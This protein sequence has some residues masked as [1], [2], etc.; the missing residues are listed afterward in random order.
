[1][2]YIWEDSLKPSGLS[3]LLQ[4]GDCGAAGARTCPRSESKA[5]AGLGDHPGLLLLAQ[6]SVLCSN[7][8]SPGPC[9]KLAGAFCGTLHT[10]SRLCL[11]RAALVP[12][13]SFGENELFDQVENSPGSW[14]RRIQNRLQKVMGISLPLFHGRGV[15]QYSFGLLP[16]RQ[17]IT[18]VGEPRAAWLGVGA[19]Y[20][21]RGLG[22]GLPADMEMGQ[23]HPRPPGAH[24]REGET[25][26]AY[27]ADKPKRRHSL[28]GT[29]A[30]ARRA[31]VTADDRVP[32]ECQTGSLTHSSSIYP[33]NLQDRDYHPFLTD[34]KLRLREVK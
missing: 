23:T 34:G 1:M 14:L 24:I 21:E 25:D 15:F 3:V 31:V 32:A 10:Y 16:Y 22:Y 19:G 28:T 12:I 29:V 7:S 11:S 17:P 2:F 9:R 13:F 18:T 30:D 8:W 4:L 26:T 20:R 27:Q 33:N 6:G 5:M